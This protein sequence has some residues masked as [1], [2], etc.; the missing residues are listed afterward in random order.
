MKK[1]PLLALFFVGCTNNKLEIKNAEVTS[2]SMD[3]LTPF[4]IDCDVFDT[5]FSYKLERNYVPSDDLTKLAILLSKAQTTSVTSIDVRGK[6]IITTFDNKTKMLCFDTFGR[7][8]DGIKYTEN[9]PLLKF[10]K[11]KKLV[12]P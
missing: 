2:V 7:F 5:I 12:T 10:L 6:L 4:G 9:E 11:T 3:I 8:Y 1:L